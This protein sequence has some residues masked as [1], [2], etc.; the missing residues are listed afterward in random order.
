MNLSSATDMLLDDAGISP[1]HFTFRALQHIHH[2]QSWDGY[3]ETGA[4]SR[5]L[6]NPAGD[7]ATQQADLTRL[8]Y[9]D[10]RYRTRQKLETTL[11]AIVPKSEVAPQVK[12]APSSQTRRIP[13]FEIG[14]PLPPEPDAELPQQE[15]VEMVPVP[16]EIQTGCRRGYLHHTYSPANPCPLCQDTGVNLHD[17][18]RRMPLA[19]R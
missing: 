18:N 14:K 12:S 5:W 15:P 8:L 19:E 11:N 3:T 2:Q 4:P 17:P 16:A 10:W 13:N 9:L 1:E 6:C 7:R